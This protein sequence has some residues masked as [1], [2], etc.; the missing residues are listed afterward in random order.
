ML[1]DV[2]REYIA[3]GDNLEEKQQYL[4]GALSAWNIACLDPAKREKELR[5]Y[6]RS[7][8]RLNPLQTARDSRDLMENM[9]LLIDRKEELYPDVNIQIAEA[10][11]EE[12]GGQYYVTVASVSL[13]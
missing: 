12:Q 10:I 11:I 8:R 4:N 13:P 9:R 1:L 7:C 5:R 6:C 3:M 2:A